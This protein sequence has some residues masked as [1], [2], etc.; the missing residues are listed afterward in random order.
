LNEKLEALESFDAPHPLSIELAIRTV[1][2]YLAED[3]FR[4]QLHGLLMAEVDHV[5][6]ATKE[7]SM[8]AE[9][10]PDFYLKRI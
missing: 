6:S 9:I 2:K 10:T 5:L 3:R 4:I 1:K 7:L 8:R